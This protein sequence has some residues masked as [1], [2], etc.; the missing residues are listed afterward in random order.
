MDEMKPST[1]LLNAEQ[2]FTSGRREQAST[3]LFLKSLV[4]F[5]MIKCVILW[6]VADTILTVKTDVEGS[7]IVKV[8]LLP[9]VIANVY[10]QYFFP[11]TMIALIALLFV[12]PNYLTNFILFWVALNLFRLIFPV[13]NGSDYVLLI[14]ALI[15]IPLSVYHFQNP[16]LELLSVSCYN[17]FRML[18]QIQVVLIYLISAW[19]KLQSQIWRSGTAFRYIANL[20]TEFNPLFK[21]LITENTALIMAW[22]T[23]VFELLFVILVWKKRTRLFILCVGTIFHVVIWM[24]LNLPDFA[25]VMILSYLLFLKDSDWKNL[26]LISKRQLQ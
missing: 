15:S 17:L 9:V 7:L 13:T 24:M 3:V 26:S 25:L 22:T 10:S 6:S 1:L 4:I 2:Y 12:R 11:A 14:L 19:D 23:I 5:A 21:N 18:A 16:T 8:F 20:E